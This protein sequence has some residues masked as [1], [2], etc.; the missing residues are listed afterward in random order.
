MSAFNPILTN[1]TLENPC[2]IIPTSKNI[3]KFIKI[4]NLYNLPKLAK[5]YKYY[6]LFYG[7]IIND[8]AK[9]IDEEDPNIIRKL[10][11][12]FLSSIRELIAFFKKTKIPEEIV[13]PLHFSLDNFFSFQLVS[14][15]VMQD[16]IF[17][18]FIPFTNMRNLMYYQLDIEKMFN[19]ITK[20]A[21]GKTIS[22]EIVYPLTKYDGDD[23]INKIAK[24]ILS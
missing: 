7:N 20:V 1:E 18:T 19:E 13:N 9:E 4:N 14:K 8:L 2:K 6:S 3:Y 11:E 5:N 24:K 23:E 16:N 12:K 15:E 22:V 17:K 10:P 21:Y